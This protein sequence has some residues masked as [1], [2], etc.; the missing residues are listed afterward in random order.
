[1][2]KHVSLAAS[3]L[4]LAGAIGTAIPAAAAPLRPVAAAPRSAIVHVLCKYGT[5]HC[6]NPNPGPKPPGVGGAQWPDSG[7]EDPD[8][9]YYGN[10]GTATPGNWGDPTAARYGSSRPQPGQAGMRMYHR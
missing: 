6:V 9:K 5:P 1:M 4:L 7:W 8:C 10:C 2:I 3:A